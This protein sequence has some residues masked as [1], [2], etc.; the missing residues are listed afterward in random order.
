MLRSAR[1]VHAHVQQLRAKEVAPHPVLVRAGPL[2]IIGQFVDPCYAG[3][4]T[5]WR[6]GYALALGPV[7]L[8]LN[9]YRQFRVFLSPAKAADHIHSV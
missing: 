5:I 9:H 1:R 6:P 8:A 4:S 2:V 3:F 7:I